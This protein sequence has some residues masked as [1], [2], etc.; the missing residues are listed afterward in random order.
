[1]GVVGGGVGVG[2]GGFGGGGGCPSG[3]AATLV[4]DEQRVTLQRINVPR[5]NMSGMGKPCD[6]HMLEKIYG[7]VMAYFQVR[8]CGVVPHM[9]Y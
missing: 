5:W 4:G 2:W 7:R 3:T 6:M 1:V 8:Y 9:W